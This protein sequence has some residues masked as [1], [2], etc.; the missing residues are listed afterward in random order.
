MVVI[1][2]A[3]KIVTLIKI[4]TMH[5]QDKLRPIRTYMYNTN[6]NETKTI[7]GNNTIEQSKKHS[8]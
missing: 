2:I 1:S 8:K 3:I 5:L 4:Y 7:R 6:N